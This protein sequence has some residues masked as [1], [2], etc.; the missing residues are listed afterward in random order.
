MK[1][2]KHQ[3][4]LIEITVWP[5]SSNAGAGALLLNAFPWETEEGIPSSVGGIAEDADGEGDKMKPK[6]SSKKLF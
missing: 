4:W 3:I 6:M 5:F 1:N 2:T